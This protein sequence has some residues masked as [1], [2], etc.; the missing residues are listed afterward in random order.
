MQN[1]KEYTYVVIRIAINNINTLRYI[2]IPYGNHNIS[3]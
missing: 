1:N 2:I 3:S